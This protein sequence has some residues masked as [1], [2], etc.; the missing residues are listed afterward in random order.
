MKK[1]ISIQ[2]PRLHAEAMADLIAKTPRTE[3]PIHID[4]EI[5]CEFCEAVE[6]AN[7]L[8]KAIYNCGL[9]QFGMQSLRN[10]EVK[11]FDVNPEVA[12]TLACFMEYFRRKDEP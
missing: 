7:R 8:E 9:R 3:L 4:Y 6:N 10:D 1:D 11:T 2:I 12:L 5:L